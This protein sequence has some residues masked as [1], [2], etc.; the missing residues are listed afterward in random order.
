MSTLLFANNATSTLASPITSADTSIT[1]QAGTGS[2]FP[3]PTSGQVFIGTIYDAS[4]TID[5]IVLVTARTGDVLTVQRAQEGTVAQT[6]ITGSLFG[7]YP[8]AATME[9][10]IQIDQLQKGTYTFTNAGGTANALTAT[11]PSNLTSI[12]DGFT[13][14]LRA[15]NDNSGACTL[16]LTL[17]STILST[18]GIV[19]GNNY[20]LITGDIWVGYPLIL[21]YSIT[22]GSFVLQNPGTSVVPPITSYSISFLAVGGGGGGAASVGNV[23]GGGGGAGGLIN[24]TASL[25]QG[26]IYSIVVGSGGGSNTS[27]ANSQ[28]VG[29]AN[30]IGGGYGGYVGA[31]GS[32]GSGGGSSGTGT[33]GQGNNGGAQNGSAGG[34]GGGAGAAG[35]NATPSPGGGG[36]GGAGSLVSITGSGVYY[37]GGGGGG[38]SGFSGQPSG[39][40]GGIGGGGNGAGGYSYPGNGTV[41]SG[42][43]GGAGGWNGVDTA[44]GNGGSGVVILSIPTGYYSGVYSGSP[45]ITTY[46]GNTILQYLNSGTYTA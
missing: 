17:G 21:T 18:V 23:I 19:K 8:T 11:L 26:N 39:G 20:P 13:L 31:G 30:A 46:A 22:F 37:S 2:L 6:W 10:L 15:I 41:N 33:A 34:G 24:S 3:S 14:I 4:S 43:G 5:E 27:G 16:Q 9:D 40:A 45:V 38:G 29:V 44:G 7:M 35:A 42:G 25:T 12:T 32:G 1:L 36:A 28:I